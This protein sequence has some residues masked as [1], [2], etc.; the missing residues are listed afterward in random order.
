[1]LPLAIKR[2]GRGRR[3]GRG[4]VMERERERERGGCPL[5]CFSAGPQFVVSYIPEVSLSPILIAGVSAF[6]IVK[7]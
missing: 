7:D 5:Q 1:L 2:K 6:N 3:R 4:R